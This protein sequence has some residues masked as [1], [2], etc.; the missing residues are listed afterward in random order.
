MNNQLL[1][2]MILFPIKHF[3]ADFPLQNLYMLGKAKQGLAWILPLSAHCS[4]HSALSLCIILLI[5]PR[6]FWLV[7]LEFMAHFV[8][9]RIK[10]CQKLPIGPWSPESKGKYLSKYYF[11]FGMDQLAHQLT[12]VAMIY[13]MLSS[14]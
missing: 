3:L 7:G 6:L 13:I 2:M 12:Y 5:N 8:I 14:F 4:V 11:D 10:V 1:V 9:D